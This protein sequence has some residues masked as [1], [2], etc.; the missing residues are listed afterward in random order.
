MEL[1]FQP[2]KYVYTKRDGS[3]YVVILVLVELVFQLKNIEKLNDE[4]LKSR[5]PCFSGT[6]F[7]TNSHE[8]KQ[9]VVTGS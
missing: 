5:N 2:T 8:N 6:C 4:I 3:K 9:Y 1:V 7:S